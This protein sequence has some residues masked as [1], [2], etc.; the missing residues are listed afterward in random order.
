MAPLQGACGRGRAP[1]RI[2]RTGVDD[3]ME[4]GYLGTSGQLGGIND[5]CS[6]SPADQEKESGGA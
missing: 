4:V 1:A 5:R 3:D 6:H 2:P